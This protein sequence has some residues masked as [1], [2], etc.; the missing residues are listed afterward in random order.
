M[1]F[2]KSLLVDIIENSTTGFHLA[3]LYYPKINIQRQ[4]WEELELSQTSMIS[5][6]EKQKEGFNFL[7]IKFKI[8]SFFGKAYT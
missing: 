5:S 8:Y 4:I 1:F 7:N 2:V 3:Y 6:I